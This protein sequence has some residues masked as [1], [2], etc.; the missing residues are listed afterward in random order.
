MLIL[1]FMVTEYEKSDALSTKFRQIGNQH[2]K[3]RKFTDA[4]RAYNLGLNFASTE[5]QLAL[6]YA[7]RSALALETEPKQVYLALAD[8][9]RVELLGSSYPTELLS[10]LVQRKEK[11][12]RLMNLTPP[13]DDDESQA[14][15][16]ADILAKADD[17][18]MN[19]YQTEETQRRKEFCSSQLFKLKNGSKEITAAE[20]FVKVAVNDERGRHVI[21]TKDVKP[22]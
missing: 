13:C 18:Q 19:L 4:L 21:V 2:Y 20:D 3:Q 1:P 16:P 5:A 17:L 8:I 10:K 7:N 9:Q 14:L 12:T 15:S 22:G 6:C 11:C